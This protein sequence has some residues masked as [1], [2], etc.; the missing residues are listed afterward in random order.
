MPNA[1]TKVVCRTPSPGKQPKRIDSWKYELVRDAILKVL[2]T[3]TQ[4]IAFSDLSSRVSRELSPRERKTLGSIPWYTATVKL[5]MEVKREIE[6][7]PGITPQR[8]RRRA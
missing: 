6:R 5:E 2:G 3:N 7:V 1:E 4:G 8:L